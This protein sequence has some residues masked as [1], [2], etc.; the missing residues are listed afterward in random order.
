MFRRLYTLLFGPPTEPTIEKDEQGT[1]YQVGKRKLR[2]NPLDKKH[3]IIAKLIA[4]TRTYPPKGAGI[5]RRIPMF[6]L[7]D[8]MTDNVYVCAET[9]DAYLFAL[10]QIRA[11]RAEQLRVAPLAPSSIHWTQ[12][13]TF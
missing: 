10:D 3:A 4:T 6:G 7:R 8:N 1:F 5:D 2:F 11:D 12:H 13:G 9:P